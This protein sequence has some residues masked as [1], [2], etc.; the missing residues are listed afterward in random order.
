M[1]SSIYDWNLCCLPVNVNIGIADDKNRIELQLGVMDKSSIQNLL[2]IRCQPAVGS[3]SGF[4]VTFFRDWS[5][6]IFQSWWSFP[7][8]LH[9]GHFLLIHV[10]KSLITAQPIRNLQTPASAEMNRRGFLQQV[11]LTLSSQS[12]SLFPFLPIPYPYW[13]L[14]RRPTTGWFFPLFLCSC[15]H[16][17]HIIIMQSHL[18]RKNYF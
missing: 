3:S 12:P 9:H 16:N 2:S 8:I 7:L 17:H 13:P 14:L 15:E 5:N 4:N 11:S 18:N 1:T 6:K 10:N